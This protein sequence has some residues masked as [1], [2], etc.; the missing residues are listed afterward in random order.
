MT[1]QPHSIPDEAR[2]ADADLTSAPDT[3]LDETPEGLPGEPDNVPDT[4]PG[5]PSEALPG[6]A[7]EVQPRRK[8]RRHRG[9]FFGLGLLLALSL[10]AVLLL[11]VLSFSAQW[12]D[13]RL[14]VTFFGA[15]SDYV[16]GAV[17]EAADSAPAQPEQTLPR[18]ATGTGVTMTL[19]DAPAE[20]MTL[21]ALYRAVSPSVVSVL[22]TVEGQTGSGSGIIM[23][24]DGYVLTNHHVISGATAVRVETAGGEAYDAA[25][26]GSDAFS[27]LAVLK[28]E[29]EG[30][31]AAVFGSSAGLQVGD[32]VAAIGDPMGVELRGTM[33]NGII[34]AINRDIVVEDRSMTLLQTNAALNN[35]NSGGPL[36]DQ[37]GRVIGINTMKLSSRYV[38]IEGLG[39]AIP[40][41]VAKPLV[42]ELIARGYVAGRP[43]LG[44]TATAVAAQ[45]ST[46][47]NIPAGIY[48]NSVDVNS[49]AARQG[50]LAGDIITAIEDTPVLTLDELNTVKNRFRAGDTVRLTIWR[51]GETLQVGV[52]LIDR[53]Q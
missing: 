19:T 45:T 23:T 49:D 11:R 16:S 14:V 10:A 46:F 31:P 39:F 43:A 51:D 1:Q 47:Y 13:G 22:S 7:P 8:H 27:D 12:K 30:L 9:L 32:Q 29:A 17:N 25:L 41:D 53:A 26:V 52:T 40:T 37:Y 34:S 15:D 2:S 33:T 5:E 18:A 36:I 42:D 20:P 48:I 24:C 3:L 38:S 28:I 21:Q 35:G 50:L 44:I 6:E 4:L